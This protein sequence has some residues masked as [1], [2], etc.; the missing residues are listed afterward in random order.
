MGDGLDALKHL[1][2]YE[3]FRRWFAGDPE[4]SRIAEITGMKVI[5]TDVGKAV[6]SF[7]VDRRFANP[8]GGLHG[9]IL[10]TVAD[11]AMGTA[12][13]STLEPGESFASI[14]L[15]TNFLKPARDQALR[16][17][18]KVVHRGKNIA[19]LECDVTDDRD[20]L[21]ARVNSSIMILRREHE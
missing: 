21:I 20:N 17:E 6:L 19:Y 4:V 15:K 1:P 16:F 11:A 13:A 10:T 12:L 14:E 8:G 3:V 18:G 7:N 2:L 5:S 9:G